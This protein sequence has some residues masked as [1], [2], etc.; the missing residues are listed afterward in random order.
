MSIAIFISPISSP[1]TIIVWDKVSIFHFIRAFIFLIGCAFLPGANLYNIIFFKNNLHERFKVQHF[2]LKITI[3]PLFS[4]AF[5][6]LAVLVLDQLGLVRN[7]F[8]IILFSLI[9][10]LCLLDLIIQKFREKK[11]R[12]NSGFISLSKYNII[13]LIISVGVS[14]ISIG[15]HFGNL[16]LIPGDSWV[17]LAPNNYIGYSNTSPIE[18]GKINTYYPIFW[19]YISFG[20]SILCGLP[21]FNTNALLAIFCYLY[22][23]SVY[24]MMKAILFNYKEKYI[25][26]STILIS[27]T[28]NLFYFKYDYGHGGLPAITFVCEFYFIYKSYAYILFIVAI[29]FFIFLSKTSN[30]EDADDNEL[31]EIKDSKF[32]ILIAFFL[33]ISFMLYMLPL[34]MGIVFIFLYCIFSDKKKTKFSFFITIFPIFINSFYIS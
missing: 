33:T 13:I 17:S 20:L 18:W 6:G 4:F 14:L 15:I 25:T 1:K 3:Y 9:L 22:I 28:S 7:I 2:I 12:I 8:V 26:F 5:I 32:L 16:Y 10:G 31:K 27:I 23:T 11:I 34:L 19:S 29:A 24:L 30:N 21:Y